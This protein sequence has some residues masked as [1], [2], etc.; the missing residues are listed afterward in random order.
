M[1]H[2]D[3][4]SSRFS[5][6]ISA[7]KTKLMTNSLKPI[8]KKKTTVNG[9]ELKTVNQFLYLADILDEEDSK[10]EV[11]VRVVQT[12]EALAK[13]KPLWRDK[14]I[15]IS[16]KLKLLHALVLSIFIICMRDMDSNRRNAEKNRSSGNE[17]S[18]KSTHYLIYFFFFCVPQLYLCG[19]PF[20]WDFCILC[21]RFFNPTI[22]VVT[23]HLRGWCMLDVFLL[24]AF[25]HLGHEH[26][27]LLSPCD[28]MHVCTD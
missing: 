16:S 5:K 18:Q 26:Q 4:T 23:F 8:E 6:E 1:N 13:L 21:D 11:L 12:A 24:P 15:S 25:T 22:K 7:E 9:Q 28:E 14:S 10:T 3:K 20:G 19:S 2:L 27:D 17:M